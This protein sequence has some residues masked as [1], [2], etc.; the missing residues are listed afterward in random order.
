MQVS[1]LS[2]ADVCAMDNFPIYLFIY[3]FSTGSYFGA[4]SGKRILRPI[5]AYLNMQAMLGN[6]LSQNDL[7]TLFKHPKLIFQS[8]AV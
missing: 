4:G 8:M 3:P 6:I 2:L 5:W 1:D 7:K